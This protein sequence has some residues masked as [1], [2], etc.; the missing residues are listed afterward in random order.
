MKK[1]FLT[2]HEMA[3]ITGTTPRTLHHYDR[4]GLLKPAE[5]T[6]KRYRLY[7]RGNLERLQWIL[8]LKETGVPLKQ[9]GHILDLPWRERQAQLESH[10]Q[11]LHQKKER[12]AELIGSFDRYL[13]A[14]S[15]F[16]SDEK[17]SVKI[18]GITL[19]EQYGREAELVYGDTPAYREYWSRMEQ[20]EPAVREKQAFEAEQR[21]NEVFR[22][23]ASLMEEPPQSESVGNGIEHWKKTL[24]PYVSGERELLI[25]IAEN[26]RTDGRFSDYFDS[27]GGEKGQFSLFLHAAITFHCGQPSLQ[28]G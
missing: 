15:L 6:Q 1:R 13:E 28:D 19:D 5:L 10:R 3:H 23:L 22:E 21:L 4:I 9:V 14:G 24:E 25:C 2:V 12:L 18:S 7:D 8:F 20:I 16:G 26:Y 27:F 17:K 11:A